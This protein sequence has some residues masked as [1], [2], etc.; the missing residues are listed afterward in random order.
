[1]QFRLL[2]TTEPSTV[3]SLSA[4]VSGMQV[5]AGDLESAIRSHLLFWNLWRRYNA[6]PESWDWQ[7]RQLVWKGYPGRPEFIE[8]T[9][10]LY[11]VGCG[12]HRC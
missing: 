4:F 8:S 7:D 3:D 9:Y 6:M 11:H 10:Y 5:L 12:A 2:T 1:M